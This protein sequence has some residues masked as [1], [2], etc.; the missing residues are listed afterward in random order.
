[1]A[2]KVQIGN[3]RRR[4]TR[5]ESGTICTLSRVRGRDTLKAHR[6][7]DD[8]YNN[9]NYVQKNTIVITRENR[10]SGTA[11]TSTQ[12][13]GEFVGDGHRAQHII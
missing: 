7:S 9:T 13:V 4:S 6:V 10:T 11:Y 1:M 3:Q 8:D 2:I 5:K 12:C